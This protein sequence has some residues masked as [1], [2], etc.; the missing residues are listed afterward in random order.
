MFFKRKCPKCGAKNP[1]GNIGCAKCGYLLAVGHVDK[2]QRVIEKSIPIELKRTEGAVEITCPICKAQYLVNH[3]EDAI[4]CPNLD[5]RV[6]PKTSRY[7]E[8]VV[9][10][11]K[12]TIKTLEGVK[13]VDCYIKGGHITF[14][15][16]DP[17]RIPLWKILVFE[18]HGPNIPPSKNREDICRGRVSP[19]VIRYRDHSG[20]KHWL[21]FRMDMVQA[22]SMRDYWSKGQCWFERLQ[23]NSVKVFEKEPGTKATNVFG[24]KDILRTHNKSEI[25]WYAVKEFFRTLPDSERT[26][27]CRAL[28]ELGIN[29]Q[30]E[31]KGWVAEANIGMGKSIGVI[32]ILEGPIRWVNQKRSFSQG[33][34]FSCEGPP[35]YI[36][37]GIPDPRLRPVASDMQIQIESERSFKLVGNIVD[38]GW[39]GKGSAL[40]VIDRMSRDISLKQLIIESCV[41]P[42]Y[43]NAYG[44][45]RCWI[46]E[47]RYSTPTKENWSCYQAIARHLLAEW[48]VE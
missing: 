43:I 33:F 24:A 40:R 39:K 7:E 3:D 46:I 28:R 15:M 34:L 20:R 17:L 25:L 12:A 1:K 18:V 8:T 16:K 4:I 30:L 42:I 14:D 13:N 22:L 47:T 37:F 48:T 29:A 31:I 35:N 44:N 10:K 9:V 5:C 6:V 26:E 21:E 19:V 2:N 27:L 32:D 11:E 36:Q 38:L 23:V 45:Y 41:L